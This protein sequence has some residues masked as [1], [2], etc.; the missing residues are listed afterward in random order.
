VSADDLGEQL[1]GDTA[2]AKSVLDLV[3][4]AHDAASEAA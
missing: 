1:D 4:E 2:R 3:R